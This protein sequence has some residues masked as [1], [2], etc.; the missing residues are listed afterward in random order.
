[1][2]EHSVFN[3]GTG[4]GSSVLEVIAAIKDVIDSDFAVDLA[5]RRAGDPAFLSADVSRIE[6]TLGWKAKQSLEDIV[7]S[8]YKASLN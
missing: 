7:S 1:V 6:K 3:V 4:T 8:H 5:P 2:R